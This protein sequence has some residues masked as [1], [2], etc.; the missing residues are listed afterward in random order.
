M[1]KRGATRSP[2]TPGSISSQTMVVTARWPADTPVDLRWLS[3]EAV[4]A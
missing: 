2:W 1:A 4:G 3:G